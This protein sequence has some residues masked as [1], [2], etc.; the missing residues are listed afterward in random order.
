ML[1]KEPSAVCHEIKQLI[2]FDDTI[3]S[4]MDLETYAYNHDKHDW[5]WLMRYYKKYRN[6]FFLLLRGKRQK[7]KKVPYKN[8]YFTALDLNHKAVQAYYER[9]PIE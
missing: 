5:I 8:D 9:H 6:F 1:T 3:L 4:Y 7:K 2:M